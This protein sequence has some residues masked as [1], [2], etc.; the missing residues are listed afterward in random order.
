[1]SEHGVAV[2]LRNIEALDPYHKDEVRDTINELLAELA[3]AENHNLVLEEAVR[4]HVERLA[5]ARAEL[6]ALKAP[7]CG[8]CGHGDVDTEPI[9]PEVYC[10]YHSS[11]W[12]CDQSCSEWA[13]RE[14]AD[15][16]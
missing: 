14:E 7:R 9:P 5:E 15:D 6:A 13:A 10:G 1:M 8:T 11:W 3:D 4:L 16:E 2:A 12:A